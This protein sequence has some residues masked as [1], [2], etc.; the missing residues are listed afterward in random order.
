MLLI[1]HHLYSLVMDLIVVEMYGGGWGYYQIMG[2][3]ISG[4]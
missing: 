2:T 4:R 3:L 1:Y